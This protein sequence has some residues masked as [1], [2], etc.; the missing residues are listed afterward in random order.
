ML[1]KLIRT[2]T[3]KQE[4]QL[5]NWLKTRTET[6]PFPADVR[7]YENLDYMG[8]GQ[9]CHRM[10]VF[11]PA[12][13]T[14][15]LPLVIDLHG[16]GFL[17]GK[18]EVNRLFC[19]DLC[20]RGYVVF[21]PEYPLCP[22]ATVFAILRTLQSAI[23]KICATAPEYGGDPARLYLCGDSAGAWLCVYLAAMEACPELA[24]AATMQTVT[25][26]PIRAI[27]LQSGMFYTRRLDKIGLFLPGMIYG[28]HW[29]RHPFSPYMDPENPALLHALPPTYLV[30]AYGDFL[31]H[32]S[33]D[34][35]KAIDHAGIP[36]RF[37]DITAGVKLPH[38]FPAMLPENP[39]AQKANAEMAQFFAAQE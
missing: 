3:A 23:D 11:V 13:H 15:A 19:A 4:A 38:A 28:K 27:G 37:C 12:D 36:H 6:I 10:D 7:L 35:A 29:H 21:C 2:Q 31:R 16:G 34:F 14:D 24:N 33:R 5:E 32:Y 18:K 20:K 39:Y 22:D 17:L 1:T 30:T 26:H 8:D 9:M 25:N